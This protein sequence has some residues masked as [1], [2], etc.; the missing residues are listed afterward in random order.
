[1]N[2]RKKDSPQYNDKQWW[3]R[4]WQKPP[5]TRCQSNEKL[6]NNTEKEQNYTH[7]NNIRTKTEAIAYI[8]VFG[9]WTRRTVLAYAIVPVG[10][11]LNIEY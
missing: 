6:F 7:I 5:R 2:E 1:M 8:S 3:R 9:M 11:V 10:D 4:Q